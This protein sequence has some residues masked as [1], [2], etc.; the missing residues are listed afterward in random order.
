M[1]I[2]EIDALLFG[3]VKV[4]SD[5]VFAPVL[6]IVGLK[7]R[8]VGG[9]RIAECGS[10]F[11]HQCVDIGNCLSIGR[12]ALRR[13]YVTYDRASGRS[14]RRRYKCF[15][16][17]RAAEVA[18]KLRRGRQRHVLRQRCQSNFFPLLSGEEI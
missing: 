1:K 17:R 11:F 2:T 6:R 12:D 8:V 5:D 10:L 3:G 18:R 13:Q 16:Q 4:N 7:G 9:V 15:R 14:I